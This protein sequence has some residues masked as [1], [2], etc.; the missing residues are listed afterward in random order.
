MSSLQTPK[1]VALWLFT[2]TSLTFEQIAQA[3]GL[4]ILEVQ[5]IADGEMA[6]GMVPYDPTMT[7]EITKEEILRCQE[8]PQAVLKVKNV[9]GS[10][11]KKRDRK[12]SSIAKRRQKPDAILWLLLNY[13]NL[14]ISQIVKLINTTPKIINSIKD[15]TYWNMENIKPRDPILLAICTQEELEA[16]ILKVT[17]AQETEEKFRLMTMQANEDAKEGS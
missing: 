15:G 4:H 3:C 16:E 7:G 10:T 13:P 8:D 11:A 1:A 12:Y 5:L 6:D 14:K 17:I 2:N 9:F